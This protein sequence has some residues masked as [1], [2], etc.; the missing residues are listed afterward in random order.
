MIAVSIR[1]FGVVFV[2]LGLFGLTLAYSLCRAAAIAD[3]HSMR[4]HAAKPKRAT[5]PWEEPL[6]TTYGGVW[7][8]ERDGSGL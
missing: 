1:T 6:V 4:I 3:L 8:Y 5:D 2:C 7:D